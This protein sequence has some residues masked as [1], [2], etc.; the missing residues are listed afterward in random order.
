MFQRQSLLLLSL[1]KHVTVAPRPDDQLDACTFPPLWLCVFFS[2]SKRAADD[3]GLEP[4]HAC[5]CEEW[6]C[7]CSIIIAT[8]LA[9]SQWLHCP[10]PTSLRVLTLP[11][12][13]APLATPR[14]SRDRRVAARDKAIIMIGAGELAGARGG[15]DW[16]ARRGR[17]SCIDWHLSLCYLDCVNWYSCTLYT[18]METHCMHQE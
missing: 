9:A 6:N 1:I 2:R 13:T 5:C 11:P 7:N 15:R 18:I 10:P 17:V 3:F 8:F 14:A 16:D 12:L 4:R